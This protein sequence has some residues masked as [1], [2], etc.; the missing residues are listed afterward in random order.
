[1]LILFFRY[2]IFTF[3]ENQQYVAH[4]VHSIAVYSHP[5]QR[6]K[7]PQNCKNTKKNIGKSNVT[8]FLEP[9]RSVL[10]Y[11][12]PVHMG[13]GISPVVEDVIPQSGPAFTPN[14][15]CVTGKLKKH[16][17]RLL[18]SEFHLPSSS[19]SRSPTPFPNFS[20]VL[21]L[22]PLLLFFLVTKPLQF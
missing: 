10:G 19:P 6:G 15:T 20:Q 7:E 4:L 3:Y 5:S 18:F 9:L 12:L 14:Q 17:V 1:M 13:G 22:T 11:G 8:F 21:P 2:L 16:N